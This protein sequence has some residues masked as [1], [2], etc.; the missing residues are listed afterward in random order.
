MHW[1]IDPCIQ[2]LEEDEDDKRDIYLVYLEA[3]PNCPRLLPIGKGQEPH[4]CPNDTN[5]VEN[6][7]HEPQKELKAIHLDICIQLYRLAGFEIKRYLVMGGPARAIWPLTSEIKR[8]KDKLVLKSFHPAFLHYQLPTIENDIKNLKM[9]TTQTLAQSHT[10]TIGRQ[11]ANKILDYFFKVFSNF[12][13][14]FN[15]KQKNLSYEYL[16]ELLKPP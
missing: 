4:Q 13:C 9:K 7:D 1:F 16:Y 11:R 6:V 5:E 8:L 3:N 2:A 14:G 12:M 15:Q 10:S